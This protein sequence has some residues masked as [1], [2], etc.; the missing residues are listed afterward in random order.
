M[1]A[2]ELISGSAKRIL[3]VAGLFMLLPIGC[4][5]DEDSTASTLAQRG[6]SCHS[7]LDCALGLSCINKECTVATFPFPPTGKECVPIQCRETVDCCPEPSAACEL[8]QQNCSLGS[9][10]DCT[11]YDLYCVCNLECVE[12]Q[13]ISTCDTDT[14]CGGLPCVGS[15]CV[16]CASNSDCLDTEMCVEQECVAKCDEKIDCPY[17]HDCQDGVCTDVGCTVDRE[18]IAATKNILAFCSPTPGEGKTV[19]E[20][21]IPCQTDAECNPSGA[22]GFMACIN[23]FCVDIGCESDDECLLRYP[24]GQD[25][26]CR[27]ITNL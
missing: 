20:C 27:D 8:Y 19:R 4:G 9:T 24:A 12:D 5:E 7:R 23:R 2:F 22:Y 6:E 10:T 15:K 18:C 16:E 3:L 21:Q 17:F 26:A 25:A 1:S 14:D 13:C 11:Y